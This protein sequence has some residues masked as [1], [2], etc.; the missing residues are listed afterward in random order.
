MEYIKR[1]QGGTDYVLDYESDCYT[2]PIGATIEYSDSTQNWLLSLSDNDI[3][4]PSNWI[5]AGANQASDACDKNLWIFNKCYY[6]DV[7]GFGFD[8]EY[9]K[10]LDG[11]IA[12]LRLTNYG[13]YGTPFGARGGVYNDAVINFGNFKPNQAVTLSTFKKLHDIDIIITDDKTKW[14]R[15]PVFEINDNESETEGGADQM[16]L[17]AH[18]SV[19]KDGNPDGTGNGMGWFPG[20]AIDINTGVRLN[21]GFAENSWLAT[22]NGDDMLWNPTSR[23]ANSTGNPIFGGMHFVYVF[24]A[25]DD[26]PIY[27][28]GKHIHDVMTDADYIATTPLSGLEYKKLFGDLMWVWE[29]ALNPGHELLES[30]VRIKVR[31]N[32]PYETRTA[33]PKSNNGRPL[34]Q[35]VINDSIRVRTQ[36]TDELKSALDMIN[37]VPNPYYAYS[38]YEFSRLDT[39]VKITNIPEQCEITIFNMQGALVR[40]FS[41]DDPMT[42]L[43]WDLKNHKGIP[44]ASGVYIIHV[45]VPGVGE[46]ILKWYGVMRAPDLQGF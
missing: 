26:M 29:P 15:C 43:D 25:T 22:E 38:S 27:D 34:Y 18:A 33:F 9:E 40:Q 10:L 39:R 17:R 3:F 46:K 1:S 28:E 4:Y 2:K 21:M 31:I 23:Y 32:K 45:N 12:P 42:S 20:Y 14:T 41:K 24:G 16:D 13:V 6:K 8:Q 5:R 36:N 37:I 44:I 19:D 11:G 7:T 30:E 35:F